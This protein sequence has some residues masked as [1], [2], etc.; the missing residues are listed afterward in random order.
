M[1][2]LL[3]CEG[4]TVKGRRKKPVL[5][6]LFKVPVLHGTTVKKLLLSLGEEGKPSLRK[7]LRKGL[8]DMSPAA[9]RR[10]AGTETP[11]GDRSGFE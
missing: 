6:F 5:H 2:C 8:V 4:V 11:S 7:E 3:C 10:G 9:R 1:C